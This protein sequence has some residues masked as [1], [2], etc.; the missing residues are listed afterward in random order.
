[1]S[2]LIRLLV[3]KYE[4]RSPIKD[5]YAYMMKRNPTIGRFLKAQSE[6]E[7]KYEKFTVA[8]EKCGAMVENL[9]KEKLVATPKVF[10]CFY[11]EG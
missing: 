2:F 9:S 5:Y 6:T 7:N 11:V 4:L 1:M 10:R 3:K 8:V